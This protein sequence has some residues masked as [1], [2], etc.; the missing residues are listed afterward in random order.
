MPPSSHK[1]A[2]ALARRLNAVMPAGFELTAQHSHLELR[3]DGAWD[4]AI[5]TPEIADDESRELKERLYTAVFGVLNS[6]QDSVSERLRT[7]WPSV[8][9]RT[10]AMPE[11]RIATDAVHLWYGESETGP[12]LGLPKIPLGEI[13][14]S[15]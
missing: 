9:G 2:I 6:V 8:D 1:L 4:G 13:M 14:R 12:V 11:A 3:I 7:P 10:M 15:G 5:T